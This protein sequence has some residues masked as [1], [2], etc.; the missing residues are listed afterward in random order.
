MIRGLR[1]YTVSIAN[2]VQM[3]LFGEVKRMFPYIYLKAC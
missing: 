1:L 2:A 3:I